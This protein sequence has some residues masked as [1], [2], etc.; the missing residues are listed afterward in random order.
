VLVMKAGEA[1]EDAPVRRLFAEPRAAYSRALMAAAPRLGEGGPRDIPAGPA[2]LRAEGVTV[3]F[4]G[5][6]IWQR[7]PVTV[8]DG[9][10][11]T[12]APG[13]TLGLVG[14]SGCGKSTLARAILRLGPLTDGKVE[15]AGTDVTRLAGRA[16]RRIRHAAQM[17]FQDP[18]ASLN[19]RL[20]AWEAVSEPAFIQ[21]LVAPRDRR[22]LAADLVART[23]LP[24]DCVDRYPHQFSGGQRQRLS[25]ARALSARPRLIVADEPVSALDV[26]VAR[27][28]T[29]LMRQLQEEEGLAFL[30]I[31]HDMA[32]VERMAHRI[33]VMKAGRIVEE[34]PAVQVLRDPQHA[35]TRAL[36]AAVPVP[37][38]TR[39]RGAPHPGK[40]VAEQS[41]DCHEAAIANGAV[42]N[43]ETAP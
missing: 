6:G 2:V 33:A 39:R 20:P 34:G 24:R 32:V 23:G 11:L 9:V 13:E 14:E 40:P 41:F 35:Y 36:I 19:P 25:I 7:A 15:I 27:Q 22:D 42:T 43:R 21:N 17:I 8:V 30:F 38:P 31:S 29:D 26:S 12:V 18:Y 28:V 10:S 3:R 16:L 37:D 1:V 4:G 5:G